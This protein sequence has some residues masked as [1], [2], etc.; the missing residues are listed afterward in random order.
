MVYHH[1]PSVGT[2]L[3]ADGSDVYGGMCE[4]GQWFGPDRDDPEVARADA[5]KH[6]YDTPLVHPKRRGTG[7]EAP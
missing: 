7:V 1:F 3:T 5:R 4:C 6:V 2:S